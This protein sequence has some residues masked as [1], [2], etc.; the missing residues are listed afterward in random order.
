MPK[1]HI[2]LVV[3]PNYSGSAPKPT[4]TKITM[5]EIDDETVAYAKYKS[6]ELDFVAVPVADTDAVR[7]SAELLTNPEL[8]VFWVDINVKAAPFDNV[9]VRQAFAAAIDRDSFVKNVLHGRGLS[10]GTLIPK[11]M[12]NYRPDLG[13][14]FDASAAKALLASSGVSASSLNGTKYLYNSNSP[15]NK[16]IA[17]FVQAQLKTNLGVDI[18]LDGTDSKTVGSRLRHQ[19]Y[20]FGG[21]SGWGADYPDSQDWFDVM[22]TGAGNNFSAYASTTYDNATTQGDAA[23][24]NAKRDALYETAEKTLVGDAPLIFLYQRTSWWLVKPYVKGLQ[25]TPIDYFLG[26]FYASSVQIAQ[27]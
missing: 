7:S 8:T 27:H 3:N 13:Q 1:D 25:V 14:K 19:Q 21:P 4:I 26:D 22:M 9:K 10:A 11:G 15:T 16:T 20:Q 17:E 12:R 23:S 2:T 5:Y 6:G 18:V 24:D